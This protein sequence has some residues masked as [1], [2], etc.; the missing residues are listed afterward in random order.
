MNT[1]KICPSCGAPLPDSLPAHAVYGSR[2]CQRI[3]L[4]AR[5]TEYKDPKTHPLYQHIHNH[6]FQCW[7]CNE[8]FPGTR[9]STAFREHMALVHGWHYST[10]T[11]A[12]KLGNK[13]FATKN[14]NRLR[15]K[16]IPRPPTPI[17]KRT[18]EVL[19]MEVGNR[20]LP[21]CSV[22]I[23]DGRTFYMLK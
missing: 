7:M 5:R 22:R 11:Y 13:E 14:P 9:G 17:Q 18:A 1:P 10:S 2:L 3:A 16:D 20:G 4:S 21:V 19:D 23:V 15:K 6:A 12:W 8:R